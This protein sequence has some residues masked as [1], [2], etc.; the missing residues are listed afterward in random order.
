MVEAVVPL[1][2]VVVLL[3]LP[4]LLLE[5]KLLLLPLLL[6]QE[7]P[8]LVLLLLL[9]LQCLLPHQLLKPEVGVDGHRRNILSLGLLAVLRKLGRMNDPSG[10]LLR[11]RLRCAQQR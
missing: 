11:L 4:Q 3:L 9:Q 1:L 2:I 8:L 10:V 7:P 6:L 5:Q